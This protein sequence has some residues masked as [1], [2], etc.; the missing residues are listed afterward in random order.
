MATTQ[1]E[2]TWTCRFTN[3]TMN[4]AGP[5]GV[6]KLSIRNISTSSGNVTVI[7]VQAG[8]LGGLAISGLVLVPG[9][10]PLV[11]G[12]GDWDLDNITITAG[13]GTTCE[14]IATKH[15]NSYS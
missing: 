2:S 4:I 6:K 11:L 7:G 8:T 10:N 12:R 1:Y 5:E 9:D 3:N 13:S 15:I 14:V